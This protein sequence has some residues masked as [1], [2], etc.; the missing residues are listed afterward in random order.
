DHQ[1]D[2]VHP[3]NAGEHVLEKAPVAW[4]I[5]DPDPPPA[6]QLHVGEAEVDRHSPALLLLQ[7]V[8]IDLRQGQH[9]R[10]LAVVDV[11]GGP[12]D[13][14][15]RLEV[16]HTS[17]PITAS[18]MTSSSPGRTVRGSR[19]TRSSTIRPMT[20][21]SCSRKRRSRSA[22]PPRRGLRAIA[23]VGS[24]SPGSEPPPTVD[25]AA[26]TSTAV[27]RSF[28]RPCHARA[29]SAID[30]GDAPSMSQTGR[31]ASDWVK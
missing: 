2:R 18:T 16:I 11:T 15:P 17:A 13:E 14:R 28:S 26:T 5:D 22:A 8:G 30:S 4:Y 20:G 19:R 23:V 10:R 21:G 1:Q 29:R 9:Q 24:C 12:D 7:P 31:P 6:G 27:P 25:L 3:V